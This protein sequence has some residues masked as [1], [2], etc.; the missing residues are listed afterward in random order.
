MSDDFSA[1]IAS[2][3]DERII[4]FDD[5]II[6]KPGIADNSSNGAGPD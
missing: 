2:E 1:L 3:R 6:R 4:A 5:R